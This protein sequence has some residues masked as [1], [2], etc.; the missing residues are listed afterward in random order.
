M[1]GKVAP[2]GRT[3]SGHSRGFLDEP[4]I[5]AFSIVGYHLP[6]VVEDPPTPHSSLLL[7]H[8]S[9]DLG[10]SGLLKVGQFVSS[11]LLLGTGGSRSYSAAGP[12]T[13][14]DEVFLLGCFREGFLGEETVRLL[15]LLW[16]KGYF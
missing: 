6:A 2:L 16:G 3:G 4:A 13:K 11:A 9:L 1:E 7:L 12:E 15:F 8:V 10:G 5:D 14:Q